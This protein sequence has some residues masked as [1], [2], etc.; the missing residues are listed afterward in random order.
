VQRADKPNAVLINVPAEGIDE[1]VLGA[2]ACDENG[3]LWILRQ[4]MLQKSGGMSEVGFGEFPNHTV[5]QSVEVIPAPKN[6]DR[7]YYAVAC[8]DEAPELVRA[9]TASFVQE[10]DFVRRR[11]QGTLTAAEQRQRRLEL[12]L[13]MAGGSPETR[14]K[15]QRK[16]RDAK[17]IT[18]KQTPVWQALLALLGSRMTNPGFGI[19]KTDAVVHRHGMPPILIEIKTDTGSSSIQQGLGQLMIYGDLLEQLGEA[20]GI[21]RVLLL[22]GKPPSAVSAVLAARGIAVHT[23][24]EGDP[25]IFS[26]AFLQFVSDGPA[27][28]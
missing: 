28:V 15:Y 8:V 21:A 13:K 27:K 14:E 5:L 24:T 9:A 20:A 23:Y 3:G 19:L 16:A 18:V 11:K 25:I 7:Q 4:G 17:E 22:P 6:T 12:A 2:V 10:C 26:A 1:N